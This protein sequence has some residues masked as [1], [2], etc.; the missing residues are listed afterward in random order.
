MSTSRSIR[1]RVLNLSQMSWMTTFLVFWV[2]STAF[3]SDTDQRPVRLKRSES[4]LG[5]HLDFHANST[6]QNI[7]QNTTTEMVHAILDMVRPDYI[8]VD[9]KGHAGYSSYPTQVG[10]QAGSFVGDPLRIWREVT[11]Q[12]GVGLYMH[13]SGVWDSKAVQ[14]HPAWAVVDQEGNRSKDKA[15]VFGPY[16]DSLLIPQLIELANEYRVDGVWVDG[17]CWATVM[18]YSQIAKQQFTKKTGI[19]QIPTDPQ[20]ANWFEWTEFHRE[21]FREYLR[22]YLAEVKKHAPEL[23]IASNWAFTDHMPEAVCCPVDFISGDYPHSNSVVA[24][25][26]SSRFMSTQGMAWDLMAWSFS[27]RQESDVWTQ[28]P[29]VQLQREAACV[30]SQGGGFQAYYTQNRDGSLNLDKLESMQQTAHFCRQRQSVS[31]Q[32]KAVPQVALLC[33]TSDH[34]RRTS[35]KNQGLFPWSIGWQR[36]ILN[37]LLE[38]QYSVEVF[39]ET[40]LIPVLKGYPLL[41]ISQWQYFSPELVTAVTDYVKSGG[42]LLLIGKNIA[43]HFDSLLQEAKA[44]STSVTRL[45][46]Q[47]LDVADGKVAVLELNVSSNT[48]PA[49][50]IRTAVESLQPE[51][52]IQVDGCSTV[53]VSVRTSRDGRFVVHLVNTSGDHESDAIIESIDP[54]GPIT[55]TIHLDKLPQQVKLVPSGKPLDWQYHDKVLKVR[56]EQVDI[57]EI[58]VI[59]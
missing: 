10:N 12:R 15:S 49:S 13:Y 4:F 57:H 1:L 24:A 37:R 47:R 26:Y 3:C 34:Y 14:D 7:G 19:Q 38:S 56:V 41:V 35:Q 11:A 28:K 22:H 20:D 8:Q 6:D 27:R 23:Q 53:D 9:C 42:K 52:L 54:I 50:A 30:L 44:V 33:S 59:E 5:L 45:P 39:N 29:S 46:L 58:L 2:P 55:I 32:S 36:P 18:D 40:N 17:E 16:A 21:A 43:S 51:F 25:R 48:V 31:Y